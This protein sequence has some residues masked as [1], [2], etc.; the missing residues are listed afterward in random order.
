MISS[1]CL[2][3]DAQG[4]LQGLTLQVR[5]VIESADGLHE[6]AQRLHGLKL[7][8]EEFATAMQRGIA[9]ANLAGQAALLEELGL[10]HP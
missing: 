9:I 8:S 5:Q 6:M 10:E 7:N 1:C 3:R 4:A 2:A